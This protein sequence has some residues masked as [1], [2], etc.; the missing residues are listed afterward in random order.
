MIFLNTSKA[1]QNKTP[2]PKKKKQSKFNLLVFA[3]LSNP[4]ICPDLII[5]GYEGVAK[6]YTECLKYSV[7]KTSIEM[8][9]IYDF[10]SPSLRLW[11]YFYTSGIYYILDNIR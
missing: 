1:K 5:V 10:I 7:L 2:P 8:I 6:T 9:P 11:H 3:L 4:I